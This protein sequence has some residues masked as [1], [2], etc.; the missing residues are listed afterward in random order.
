MKFYLTLLLSTFMTMQAVS[1]ADIAERIEAATAMLEKKQGSMTPIPQE[2]LDHAK[3]IA[4]ATITKAGIG[5]GG[6]GGEGIVLLHKPGTPA[7]SW[8]APSAFNISGGSLGAQIGFATN[9]VIIVLNTD[10]AVR[11]FSGSGKVKWDA[12]ASGT[13]GEDNASESEST[14]ALEGHA[15]LFYKDTG[16]LFGGATFGGITIE[17]KN[18]INH[19]FYGSHIYVRDI[20]EGK[21]PAP[22]EA[23][24]LYHVLNGQK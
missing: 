21:V 18:S 8:S 9:R 22:H 5:I 13:A 19:E 3:G 6:M 23:E 17:T 16:G 12:T 2:I 24:R 7:P 1:A 4:F 20:F 10:A 11:Q 14:A 15:M